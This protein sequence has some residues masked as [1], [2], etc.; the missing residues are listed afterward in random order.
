[1]D[2]G[3]HSR[4]EGLLL[5][6]LCCL[7]PTAKGRCACGIGTQVQICRGNTGSQGATKRLHMHQTLRE[8]QSA[9]QWQVGIFCFKVSTH[10]NGLPDRI[11]RSGPR[12]TWL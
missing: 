2:Q 7:P 11:H 12:S 3:R 5:P 4:A 9:K 8:F 6:A 1:M 10:Q